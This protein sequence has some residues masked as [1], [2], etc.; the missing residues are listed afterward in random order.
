M[1]EDGTNTRREYVEV[2]LDWEQPANSREIAIEYIPGL[3]HGSRLKGQHHYSAV[4]FVFGS[5]IAAVVGFW[6]MSR[7]AEPYR[8]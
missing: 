5:L 6:M 8:K 2:P 4:F 3:D 1:F 7:P